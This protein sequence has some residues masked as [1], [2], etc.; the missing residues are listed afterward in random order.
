MIDIHADMIDAET[1]ADLMAALDDMRAAMPGSKL[2]VGGSWAS[3][4]TLFEAQS[5]KALAKPI[6]AALPCKAVHLDGWGL[7]CEPGDVIAPHNH[8]R[9]HRGLA[10]DYAGALY[11]TD[12]DAF[13]AAEGDDAA[14]VIPQPG[15]C[16]IFAATLMHW[17]PPA[18]GKRYVISFNVVAR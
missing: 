17:T 12:G 6:K 1:C 5:F 3:A 9:S 2:G 14:E 18:S 10:N 15:M 13:M 11:L 4:K 16:L 8:A 7:I